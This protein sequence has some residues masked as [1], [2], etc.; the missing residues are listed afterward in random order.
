[1]TAALHVGGATKPIAFIGIHG[2]PGG[3]P[4]IIPIL[5]GWVRT[6]DG[7]K[8]FYSALQISLSKYD[9]LGRANSAALAKVTSEPITAEVQGAVEG[10][11]SYLWTRT[12]ADPQPWTIDTPDGKT[13]TFSTDC[14]QSE[15]FTATFKVTATDH[16]GQSIDSDDV[17]VNNANI[18]YGGGYE[19]SAPP[20]PGQYYP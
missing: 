6:D 18:F 10:V 1:M 20:A 8:Q 17:T 14:D 11:A 16:A 15:N 13:T 5:E 9:A 4:G 19:G 7:L 3:V 2:T 12:D